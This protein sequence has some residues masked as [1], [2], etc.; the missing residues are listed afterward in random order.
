MAASISPAKSALPK[1]PYRPEEALLEVAQR[2]QLYEAGRLDV[3]I[4]DPELRAFAEALRAGKPLVFISDAHD[5]AERYRSDD[6][7]LKILD[8]GLERT[9]LKCGAPVPA[10]RYG[11]RHHTLCTLHAVEV[12]RNDAPRQHRGRHPREQ[13][14]AHLRRM[15]KVYL[16]Q[17]EPVVIDWRTSP[18][19]LI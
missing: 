10:G 9:C 14:A 13:L 5:G 12:Q 4:E 17:L 16:K 7:V 18:E 3:L 1:H 2:L 11:T 8:R 6:A 15:H 19:A